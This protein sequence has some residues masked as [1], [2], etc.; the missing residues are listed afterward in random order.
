MMSTASSLP[1]PPAELPLGRLPLNPLARSHT[2]PLPPVSRPLGGGG[3]APLPALAGGPPRAPLQSLSGPNLANRPTLAAA[4]ANGISSGV[5]STPSKAA[6]L[7]LPPA[8]PA[9]TALPPG[10]NSLGGSLRLLPPPI[11][12]ATTADGMARDDEAPSGRVT[13]P[14]PQPRVASGA[15]EVIALEASPGMMVPQR[16]MVTLAPPPPAHVPAAAA[17]SS[18]SGGG[19]GKPLRSA[20]SRRPGDEITSA[21]KPSRRLKFTAEPPARTYYEPCQE[22]PV[23]EYHKSLHELQ[24]IRRRREVECKSELSFAQLV[25][26]LDAQAGGEGLACLAPRKVDPPYE[27][28]A[29]L[30]KSHGGAGYGAAGY[31]AAAKAAGGGAMGGATWQPPSGG[32]TWGS[33][34]ATK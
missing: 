2:K 19:G 5:A 21:P 13:P 32:A 7:P 25:S 27:P 24:N 4:N 20:L 15:V 30:R 9:V 17:A 33:M 14:T 10:G 31:G 29:W 22:R 28:G 26:E 18:A 16:R 8:L 12:A 6:P 1:L 23:D 34:V 11:A 3:L